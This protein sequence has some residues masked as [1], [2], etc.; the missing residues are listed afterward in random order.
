MIEDEVESFLK[1]YNLLTPKNNVIVAFSGGYDSMCLLDVMKKLANKYDLNLYAIHLNHNW[2]GK[3]SDLE[4][5]N[6][7]KFA[8]DVT[9]YSEKL[10]ENIP[11]TETAAREARYMFFKKCAEKFKSQV[12]LTAHNANDNAETVFYR[13]LKGTGITGL[14]GINEKR[15]IYYRPLLKVY[16]K[17]IEKY[18]IEYS[19]SPNED[20]SNNDK[21]YVRNKI[22]HDIFPLFPDIIE[23]LNKLS[24]SSIRACSII[25]KH[26]KDLESYSVEDFMELDGEFKSA[27]VH[28]FFRDKNLDYDSKKIDY[29]LKFI[30]DNSISKCG[31]T[32]SLTDN[33][34]LFV[35]C[36]DISVVYGKAADFNPVVISGIG[37][38]NL[39]NRFKLTIKE[40]ESA[41]AIFPKDE[42]FKAYL[43][44]EDGDY[45][46]RTRKE[47]D[48]IQPYG[49]KGSQKLKK[50]LSEKHV[51]KHKRDDIILLA[52]G[53]EI[54]W[55]AGLGISEKAKAAGKPIYKLELDEIS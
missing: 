43:S 37:V 35:S 34:W 46:V 16:R 29:V 52:K 36:R 53:N 39:N 50:Y 22:R 49:M 5:E 8:H 4:E 3:E 6:C 21:K 38:Y 12:V 25:E 26:I 2:R 31:K 27:V 17:D 19:L 41:P 7:R 10:P 42:D 45:T 24:A 48:V 18:C 32:L 1:K 47:G 30:S 20:S 44:L 33:M 40:C 11:H 23:K 9:F 13:I 15:D 54:L 55:V 14:Q 28:K 51:P